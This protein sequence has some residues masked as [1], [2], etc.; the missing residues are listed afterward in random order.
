[1]DGVRAVAPTRRHDEQANRS[2]DAGGLERPRRPGP[3]LPRPARA[4]LGEGSLGW[5]RQHPVEELPRIAADL[6]ARG[7]HSVWVPGCGLS[8]LP[9]LLALLGGER[10]SPGVIT[11]GLQR[12]GEED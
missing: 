2:Q 8:P 10:S 3:L 5:R 12:R 7:W 11:P 9:K 6:K 4:G 1:M